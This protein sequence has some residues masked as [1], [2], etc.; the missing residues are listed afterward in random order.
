MSYSGCS[1][2]VLSLISS[3]RDLTHNPPRRA[4]RVNDI[5]R[6]SKVLVISD[7]S[8]TK[9]SLTYV[10]NSSHNNLAVDLEMKASN[11]LRDNP[12]TCH[13]AL[14]LCDAATLLSVPQLAAHHFVTQN[15]L[16][17]VAP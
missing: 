14:K 12:S 10:N 4:M 9:D 5:R 1:W 15:M 13:A 6:L 7:S 16:Q 17:A 8:T 3:K 11:T 2:L